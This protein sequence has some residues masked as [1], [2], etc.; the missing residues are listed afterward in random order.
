MSERSKKGPCEAP[1]HSADC[2]GFG[3]TKDHF[4]PRVIIKLLGWTRAQKKD[5]MNFQYLSAACHRDK[6]ASTP[7]RASLLRAQLHGQF[8]ALGDHPS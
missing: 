7:L 1:E 4:T 2:N 3:N 6:D 5:P 8:L